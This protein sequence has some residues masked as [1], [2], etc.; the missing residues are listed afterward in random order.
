[1]KLDPQA[2]EAINLAIAE[3]HVDGRPTREIAAHVVSAIRDMEPAGLPWV[4]TYMD[5]LAIIG[6]QKLC[7]DWRRAQARKARTA[8][9]TRTSAPAFV[10]RTVDGVAVQV[11]LDGLDLP[12]VIEHREKLRAQRNTLSTEIQYLTDLIEAM[13]ADASLST[14]GD[15]AVVLAVREA[16]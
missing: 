8:K 11:R 5:E 9:G 6:A 16:S 12:G 7:S 2:R 4:D 1:M 3:A 14:A 13:E 15:A 10:G